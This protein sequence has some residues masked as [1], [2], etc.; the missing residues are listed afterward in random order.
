MSLLN[1]QRR[2]VTYEGSDPGRYLGMALGM[3]FGVGMVVSASGE[4]ETVDGKDRKVQPQLQ[5]AASCQNGVQPGIQAV[6]L[7][8]NQI[9]H[10]HPDCKLS[11]S[12]GPFQGKTE[13]DENDSKRAGIKDC[14]AGFSKR[15]G[16]FVQSISG[17]WGV[18][19]HGLLQWDSR[20]Q[21]GNASHAAGQEGVFIRRARP[22]MVARLNSQFDV[23]V[24]PELAGNQP[25]V[26]DAFISQHP[27]QSNGEGLGWEM[28]KFK[29][30]IGLEALQDETV[31]AFN[32]RSLVTDLLPYRA[33]GVA[34]NGHWSQPALDYCGGF[35]SDAPDTTTRTVNNPIGNG[36]AFMGRVFVKPFQSFGKNPQ[37][38][39]K[40]LGLGVAGSYG[41]DAGAPGLVSP[42]Y[43]TDGQEKFFAYR[44]Q[45]QP[46]GVH[47][48]LCP[49]GSF[50]RGPL[51]II[52]EYIL[53]SQEL[54]NGTSGANRS[55]ALENSAW[56]VTGSWMLAG[57]GITGTENV[58]SKPFQPAIGS[59]GAWQL[60]ARYES[61]NVDGHAASDGFASVSSP[62]ATQ[63]QAW[64]VGVNWWLNEHIRING[65]FSRTTFAGGSPGLAGGLPPEQVFFT[66]IQITF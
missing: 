19:L 41:N 48:R 58:P 49:Q 28:G 52:A 55:A 47:W 12:G 5:A 54:S 66:R 43:V 8:A 59:W 42:G 24:T 44:R 34:Q 38:V 21:L 35:F 3:L 13:P 65:S 7:A 11:Q 17:E 4:D 61:L 9:F 60:V 22:I 33:L 37:D 45:V 57:Q 30:P 39:L 64:S 32:E 23:H 56:E 51:G 40:T 26:L 36:A 53:S 46:T 10:R 62:L 25:Q 15:N 20:T 31:T 6:E 18:S 16:F 27:S 63:A 2:F 14:Q 1:N 29:P 50:N